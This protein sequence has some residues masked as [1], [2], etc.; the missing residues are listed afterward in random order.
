[1]YTAAWKHKFDK[2]LYW[3]VDWAV[4]VNHGNVHY[5]LGA[6]GRNLTTDCHDGTH[7]PVTDYSSFGPTTWG[8]CRIEG[9]STGINY[10]F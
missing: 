5:D 2:Q 7:T 10:K 8:G 1:M 9:F 3:Y 4:T 6:G